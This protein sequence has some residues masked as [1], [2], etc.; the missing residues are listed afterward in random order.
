MTGF[1]PK[2]RAS[3]PLESFKWG[4]VLFGV[5]RGDWEMFRPRKDL[6]ETHSAES[7]CLSIPV[8]LGEAFSWLGMSLSCYCAVLGE[9][10]W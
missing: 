2:L 1:S 4:N 8:G 3:E 10:R 7:C 5:E 9:E 6:G